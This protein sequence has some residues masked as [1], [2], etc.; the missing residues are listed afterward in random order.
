MATETEQAAPA[1]TEQPYNPMDDHALKGRRAEAKHKSTDLGLFTLE[2]IAE[3]IGVETQSARIYHQHAT[4]NRRN[5]DVKPG[6]LPQPDLMIGRV[7]VWH[8]TNIAV[9]IE[10]RPGRGAGGGRK[11]KA[12]APDQ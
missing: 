5:D 8:A 11:K 6:D 3:K 1:E 2:D 10:N 12:E 4:R 7:P 9:W